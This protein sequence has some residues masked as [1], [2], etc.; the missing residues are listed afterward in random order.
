[1]FDMLIMVVTLPAAFFMSLPLL[2]KITSLHHGFWSSC[3]LNSPRSSFYP[4]SPMPRVEA[5]HWADLDLLFK[6]AEKM[7]Q[8]L[9]LVCTHCTGTGLSFPLNSAPLNQ[10][11][12]TGESCR[13]HH[14]SPLPTIRGQI[15]SGTLV[16]T[17]LQIQSETS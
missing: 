9:F 12:T 17:G 14:Y 3:I 5:N 8:R 2:L 6:E 4:I 15:C 10:A 16:G 7:K 11:L 1:M 13:F